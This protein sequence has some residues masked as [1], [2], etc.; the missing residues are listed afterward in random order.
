MP[1]PPAGHSLTPGLYLAEHGDEWLEVTEHTVS[2]LD[3]EETLYR[4]PGSDT[5]YSL[6]SHLPMRLR[7]NGEAVEGDICHRRRRRRFV[8]A[9]EDARTLTPA[10][11]RWRL[12]AGAVA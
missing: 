11:G 3:A 5:A 12:A 4:D 1:L 8:P 10:Q 9:Y 2:W 6:T 7:Q